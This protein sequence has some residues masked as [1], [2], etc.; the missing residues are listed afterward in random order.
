MAY[1]VNSFY[2]PCAVAMTRLIPRSQLLFVRYEDLTRMQPPAL[3]KML[4]QFTGLYTNDTLIERATASCSPRNSNHYAA[5]GDQFAAQLADA[6]SEHAPF[7]AAYDDLLREI[8][9]YRD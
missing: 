7:Y 2:A 6:R 4:S 5:G 3:L 9:G 1:A 8:T